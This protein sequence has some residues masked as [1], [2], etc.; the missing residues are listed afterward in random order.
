ML[1][2]KEKAIR[3]VRTRARELGMVYRV[4]K[5]RIGG[6]QAYE[7]VHKDTGALLKS[8]ITAYSGYEDLQSGDLDIL[9]RDSG[10]ETEQDRERR[11][12]I[13]RKDV[14]AARMAACIKTLIREETR[15]AYGWH[16]AIGLPCKDSLT[17]K[18]AAKLGKIHNIDII[19]TEFYNELFTG[20]LDD[21]FAEEEQIL[22][23]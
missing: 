21:V 12:M 14:T 2:T 22:C 8:D 10:C 5:L 4:Q 15:H 19:N 20:I 1:V 18:A 17:Q 11:I 13:E 7:L 9:A 16:E 23:S 6:I 3:A